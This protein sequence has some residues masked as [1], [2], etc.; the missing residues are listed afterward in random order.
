MGSC[1]A[2]AAAL[3]CAITPSS[4]ASTIDAADGA[5]STPGN[6]HTRDSNIGL[7]TVVGALAEAAGSNGA[8]DGMAWDSV[9]QWLWGTTSGASP[10]FAN[11]LVCINPLMGQMTQVGSFGLDLPYFGADLATGL[12]WQVNTI[13]IQLVSPTALTLSGGTANARIGALEFLGS[14]L[15][16]AEI[17]GDGISDI[18]SN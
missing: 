6:L 10:T 16:G 3:S 9:S 8:I 15:F 4:N 12:L 14:T 2:S 7:P 5:F 13:T 17:V 11:S 1:A 18:T